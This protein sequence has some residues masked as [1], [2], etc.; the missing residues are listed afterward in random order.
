MSIFIL[1]WQFLCFCSRSY[2]SATSSLLVPIEYHN[3]LQVSLARLPSVIVKAL[4]PNT[5]VAISL[6]QQRE[7]GKKQTIERVNGDINGTSATGDSIDSILES[8][9]AIDK[10]N[11]NLL[12]GRIHRRL[13]HALAPFQREGVAFIVENDGRTLLCDEMGLG[14]TI[15]A[16]A[17][18]LYY[19]ADWPVLVIAPSSVRYHWQEQILQWLCPD[20]ISPDDV[21]IYDGAASRK[22][23]GG[24]LVKHRHKFVLVSYNAVKS[25]TPQLLAHNFNFVICDES[26]YLKN[27]KAKRTASIVPL[28]KGI[29][30]A[31]LLSGTPALSRPIELFSQLNALNPGMWDDEKQFMDRYC[32]R[33]K[34]KKIKFSGKVKKGGNEVAGLEECLASNVREL[35]A[36]LVGTVM[37][38]RLKK[39]ILHEL[40]PKKR[41]VVTVNIV[42][43]TAAHRLR[44]LLEGVREK[45][46]KA[47]DKKNHRLTSSYEI[48]K[49]GNSDNSTWARSD[50]VVGVPDDD[51]DTARERKTLLMQLFNESGPAKVPAFLKHLQVFLANKISGKLLIFGHHKLT[52]DSIEA[53]LTN[54]LRGGGYIRIDGSTKMTTRQGLVHE[55]QTSSTC[56]VALLAIGAAGV[57]L[58]FTAASTVFFAE[59]FWTPG[60]LIQA[61]DRAHRI[62]QISPV[63]VSYFLAPD[64]IDDV[65]WPLV[66]QKMKVLGELFEG[67]TNVDMEAT[68]HHTY[69]SSDISGFS[70]TQK[71]KGT[72]LPVPG[73]M[74]DIVTSESIS[75]LERLVHDLVDENKDIYEICDCDHELE[76]DDEDD[77]DDDSGKKNAFK[78]DDDDDDDVITE[79]L[80]QL[81]HLNSFESSK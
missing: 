4:P 44:T 35:H 25:L 81:Y 23:N 27:G 48:A 69:S 66:R 79:V 37:L 20:R 63:Q 43:G 41:N 55:F 2:D 56:R 19:R 33:T 64:T 80:S 42:D 29:K 39:D 60:S 32:R 75:D 18:A 38:R 51:E 70:I 78:N 73:I 15:Q 45:E 40:P 54:N 1:T 76:E 58:T 10:A 36:M 26:H 6:Q 12:S 52:L 14:K 57:A 71:E 68:V 72:A 47:K 49:S 17:A 34:N 61:E 9:G 8:R 74:A 30:R 50:E 65:L 11:M 46:K 7:R 28:I 62:G 59:L 21:I 5:L 13:L 22:K 67:Q 3:Q 31:L 24:G 77:E 53:F 16:I